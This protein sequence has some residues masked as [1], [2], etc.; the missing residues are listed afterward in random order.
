MHR[1]AK[2]LFVAALTM[3]ATVV[4][5]ADYTS[6]TVK[7]NSGTWISYSLEKLILTF[8]NGKM[9]L[10]NKEQTVEYN[11]SELNSMELTDLPSAIKESQTTYTMV[12]LEGSTVRLN[13][14]A[15]TE[16]KVYDTM[17]RLY[18]TARIGQEGT[19]VCIGNLQPGI[20]V[21]KAGKEKCKVLVK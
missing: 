3:M 12:S 16:A 10:S 11:E 8:G 2:L 9:V 17:G 4:A 1:H 14:S 20:Y 5:K 7:E 21:I 6:L 13:V 15:G 18:T 19:P